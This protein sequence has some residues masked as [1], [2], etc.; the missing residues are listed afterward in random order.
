WGRR[1]STVVIRGRSGSYCR[2]YRFVRQL[3]LAGNLARSPVVVGGSGG[4]GGE[5]S[6]SGGGGG[7]NGGSNGGGGGSSGGARGTESAAASAVSVAVDNVAGQPS[8]PQIIDWEEPDRYSFYDSDRFEE[9][10]LCSWSSEP[11]SLCNNWRGWRRPTA[12][13]GTTKKPTEVPTLCELAAR[14]VAAHIPFELVEHVYPPVP[15]QLQLRIA[16]WSFPDNEEDIRL[17]SCLANGSADEFQRGENYFRSMSV[18]DALQIAVVPITL[19]NAAL[20][21]A[22]FSAPCKALSMMYFKAQCNASLRAQGNA[23]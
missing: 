4:G 12:G 6:G 5:G 19:I 15:E 11:A 7:S 10:S 18:Q 20:Q 17:Y 2:A 9:D 16:F 8:G 14:C 1:R 23:K 21:F 3:K 13:L 22:S